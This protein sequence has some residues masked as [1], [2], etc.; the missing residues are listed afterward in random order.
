MPAYVF[1]IRTTL[2]VR[3][4][5]D[6]P[7]RSVGPVPK[8]RLSHNGRGLELPSGAQDG[9]DI[10]KWD[11]RNGNL[12]L[13]LLLELMCHCHCYP[14]SPF[15]HFH[16]N[17]PSGKGVK[18]SVC[19]QHLLFGLHVKHVLSGMSLCSNGCHKKVWLYFNCR[20]LS[21]CS[22]YY[23]SSRQASATSQLSWRRTWGSPT[24]LGSRWVVLRQ[25]SS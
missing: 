14:E 17:V 6:C 5:A 9:K 25:D 11:L 8:G 3:P 22:P 19:F 15:A 4:I 24:V 18:F 12:L 21:T 16:S 2:G 1:P 7:V 13:L 23:L 10:H 20:D